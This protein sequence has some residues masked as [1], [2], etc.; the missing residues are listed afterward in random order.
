MFVLV[1]HSRMLN[2]F[3]YLSVRIINMQTGPPT[4]KT[5]TTAD[6]PN[7]EAKYTTGNDEKKKKVEVIMKD[8]NQTG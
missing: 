3:L 2:N 4:E 5:Q 8:K 1:V 6:K 7:G